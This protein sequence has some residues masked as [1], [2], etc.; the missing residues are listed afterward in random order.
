MKLPRQ[1][2]KALAG[3]LVLLNS[4]HH[5]VP[6]RRY[7]TTTPILCSAF[8]CI[9]VNYLKKAMMSVRVNIHIHVCS[10]GELKINGTALI[11][12]PESHRGLITNCTIMRMD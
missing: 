2:S 7:L 4:L 3:I 10:F 8:V 6:I 1:L 11:A 5:G 9:F 12:T